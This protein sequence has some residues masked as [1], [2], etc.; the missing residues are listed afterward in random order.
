MIIR[1]SDKRLLSALEPILPDLQKLGIKVW[2]YGKVDALPLPAGMVQ[3]MT[4]GVASDPL[5]K[6]VRD[7][8]IMD[9]VSVYIF[10]SGTTG[11]NFTLKILPPCKFL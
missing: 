2:V 5:P 11:K 8:V 1:L 6:S 10:T 4:W 9:D 3:V 7:G